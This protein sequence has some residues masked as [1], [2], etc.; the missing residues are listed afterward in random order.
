MAKGSA[1]FRPTTGT[2][3]L[4]RGSIIQVRLRIETGWFWLWGSEYRRRQSEESIYDPCPAGWKSGAARSLDFALGSVA[5]LDDENRS[6]VTRAYDLYFPYTG[7]RQSALQRQP[8]PFAHQQDARADQFQRQRQHYPVQGGLGGYS[9]YN[10]Y[11]GAGYQL[12]CV[13][14]QTTMPKG[15]WRRPRAVLIGNSITEVWQGRT[16]NKTFF[17][18]NDYLPKGISGQTSLQISARL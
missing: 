16:D 18:D 7:Q 6:G 3:L 10:S 15:V 1:A 5:E 9:S 14:E 11:T 4:I 13:R 2:P 8:Y 17:S 12:R